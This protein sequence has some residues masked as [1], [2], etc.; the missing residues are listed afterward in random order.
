MGKRT[1]ETLVLKRLLCYCKL[2]KAVG[3]GEGDGPLS[4]HNSTSQPPPKGVLRRNE[5]FLP[6]RVS[7]HQGIW[8]VNN[9]R[10]RGRS[11]HHKV[12]KVCPMPAFTARNRGHPAADSP[13]G[14][15]NPKADTIRSSPFQADASSPIPCRTSD[16]VP[17]G[18]RQAVLVTASV[19]HR[20]EHHRRELCGMGSPQCSGKRRTPR[21]TF[22]KPG[23]R[24]HSLRCQ[25]LLRQQSNL[26][27]Y[28]RPLPIAAHAHP[29]PTDPPAAPARPRKPLR[30]S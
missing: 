25:S 23:T 11:P 30:H 1:A 22:T 16:S 24:G 2:R 12:V 19:A 18:V 29:A 14:A 27:T 28:G 15:V 21:P 9:A 6:S 7:I 26:L 17:Q 5:V 13:G 20:Q 8:G 3:S 10:K 4:P